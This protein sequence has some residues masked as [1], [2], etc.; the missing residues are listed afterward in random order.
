MSGLALAR[1]FHAAAVA[2]LL[3]GI[4]HAA[5]LLG[6][7]SEV[8]GFDDEVSPDHDFGPRCQ[9]F[10]AEGDLA[11]ARAALDGLPAEFEGLPV[12]FSYHVGPE[13]HQVEVTTAAAFFQANMA[14]DP[15]EGMSL[16]DWLLT[17]TQRLASLVGGEVFADPDGS[18]AARR[19]TLRWYPDDVWRYALAAAWLRIGQEEPFVG[20]AGARG[21]ELGS[22]VVAAR[23]VRD[24][25]RLAFLVERRWAPYSK[26][27]GTAFRRLPIAARLGPRLDEVVRAGDWRTREDALV[28]AGAVLAEATNALGLA[29]E[30]TARPE[31]FHTRDIRVIGGERFAEALAAAVTD[32]QLCTLMERLWRRPGRS[33]GRLAGTVDQAVDSVDV[34]ASPERCRAAA[35]MLGL[36]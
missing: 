13:T 4:P 16:A 19:E 25:M 1:R 6:A 9:V 11:A 30:N 24:L 15:A 23:L 33:L 31:R 20:R 3:D 26:W 2:P 35:A 8:L 29:A 27:L 36:G 32:P 28:E 34:L 14:V 21:D 22:A 17:P 10:V 7:G 5:A 18:L 12:R